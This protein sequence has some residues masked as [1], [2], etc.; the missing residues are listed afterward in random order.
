[1]NKKPLDN[2]QLDEHKIEKLKGV[3]MELKSWLLYLIK[4]LLDQSI[5]G[6]GQ[7]EKN[8]KRSIYVVKW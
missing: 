8:K 3:L 4:V 1:M 6:G 7:N 5:N 2:Y